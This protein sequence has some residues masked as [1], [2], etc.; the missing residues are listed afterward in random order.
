MSYYQLP[1]N[2]NSITPTIQLNISPDEKGKD[3]VKHLPYLAQINDP[4]FQN[5]V[6]DLINNDEDLQSYLFATEDLNRT[7]NESLQLAV[8][9]GKIND[10]AKVR[11]EFEKNNADYK[12]FQKNDNPLDVLFKENAKFDVQN[13]IIGSLLEEI[14]KGKVTEKGII[15]AVKGA[16]NPA[17]LDVEDRF[18]KLFDRKR[19]GPNDN[20]VRPDDNDDDDD[21]DDD[22]IDFPNI[23]DF[24]PPLS[25]N[26]RRPPSPRLPDRRPK[27]G[28]SDDE[29][30]DE[31]TKQEYFFPFSDQHG[32]PWRLPRRQINLDKNLKDVFGEGE[33]VLNEPKP[34]SSAPPFETNNDF[35]NQLDRGGYQKKFYFIEAE[36]EPI[37]F[38][39]K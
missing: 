4:I 13:P 29:W 33:A 23:P 34:E 10:A 3:L 28:D 16:P 7:L 27:P 39:G 12:F 19:Q 2:L 21:D 8:G 17:D 22:N 36:K 32:E 24:L 30:R 5:R 35:A 1:D 15:D 18:N 38:K 6:E 25:P 11:H 14:N 9:H 37:S 31:R 26:P 20:I